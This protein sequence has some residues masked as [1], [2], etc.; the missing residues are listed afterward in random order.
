MASSLS[1]VCSYLWVRITAKE[2]MGRS[3]HG[4]Y[5]H[6]QRQKMVHKESLVCAESNLY[7][8]IV[9]FLVLIIFVLVLLLLDAN[10]LS[11]LVSI[12]P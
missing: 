7:F 3:V 10:S 1:V 5:N 11:L 9:F 6:R 2:R 8:I 12:C 4:H